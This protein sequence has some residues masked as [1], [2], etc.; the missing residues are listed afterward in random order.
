[1]KVLIIGNR[2]HQFVYNYVKS[3]R[4]NFSQSHLEID[5]LSQD[6][7]DVSFPSDVFYTNIYTLTVPSL[8]RKKRLLKALYQHILFRKYI[9]KLD[10]Y[11]VVHIHYI[12]NIIVRDIAFFSKHICGKVIVSIW[13]SDFLRASESRK[14]N[15]T[16]LFKRAN[17]ITIASDKIIG[18]FKDY[19][20]GSSFLS[21]IALCR[22]GLEPLES[23][24][25][26]LKN[27]AG[28]EISKRKMG[29][30]INKIVIT[31]GYNASRLQHHIKIIENIER[32]SLLSPF[33]DKIEF[34][35]PVTYPKDIEYVTMIKKTTFK[36][37]FHYNMIESFL[38][39]EDIAHL[40][41]ASD[42]FIQLQPTDMLSGSMLEHL[43]ARNIVITGSWLPYDC[44]D[45]WGVFFRRIDNLNLIAN[46]LYNVLKNFVNYRNSCYKN[47]DLII[48]R[49]RWNNIIHNWLNLYI[50]GYD[51]KESY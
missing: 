9:K 44:L 26:I 28:S 35:L 15:M 10:Y 11:D 49:Y 47:S 32:C 30:C 4:D 13:G 48:N 50:N 45:Q 3:L 25:P 2:S 16:V 6:S 5:I 20:K 51:S 41:V 27:D 39:D 42:I 24:I 36:S 1:M 21:K 43:S 8:F 31:I 18:E 23:L 29:L 12:E 33:R 22:F 46:E 17:Y 40:R 37:K 38:S 14:R 7:S 34:L 19:Y